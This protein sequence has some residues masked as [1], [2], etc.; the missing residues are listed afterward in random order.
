MVTQQYLQLITVHFLASTVAILVQLRT[1]LLAFLTTS[2]SKAAIHHAL[3]R[4]SDLST[5]IPTVDMTM[6]ILT[7]KQTHAS[8]PRCCNK[9]L[10][11][12]IKRPLARF[13]VQ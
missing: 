4:I 1:L 6:A 10:I 12:Q 11:V 3:R 13:T 5:P 8:R 2:S 7:P 9:W